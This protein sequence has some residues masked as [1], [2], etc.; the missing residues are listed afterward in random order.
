MV[1]F[2]FSRSAP[3]ISP[4]VFEETYSIASDLSH[5]I[6][7]IDAAIY[8]AL[9]EKKVSEK[10]V[11]FLSVEHRRRGPEEWD[12]TELVIRLPNKERRIEMAK[13]IERELSGHAPAIRYQVQ[14][15]QR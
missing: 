7:K 10:N 1:F 8:D 5:K 6:R 14:Q 11:L 4:P 15:N 9:Y 13:I 3:H 2:Y 12:F